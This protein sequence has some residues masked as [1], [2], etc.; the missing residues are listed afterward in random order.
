MAKGVYFGVNN[1]PRKVTNIYF[2]IGNAPKKVTRAYIGIGGTPRP[3]WSSW[4]GPPVRY[5]LLST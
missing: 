3:F 1:T 5:G 2:G 4:D